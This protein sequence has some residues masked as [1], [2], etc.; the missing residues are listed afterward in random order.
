[1]EPPQRPEG[2]ASRRRFE[3]SWVHQIPITPDHL[4]PTHGKAPFTGAF[5][6]GRLMGLEPTTTGITIQCSNQ[7]NYS[8]RWIEQSTLEIDL[9]PV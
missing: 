3:S 5:D 1:M 2:G 4:H 9:W 6:L 8:R 7:L